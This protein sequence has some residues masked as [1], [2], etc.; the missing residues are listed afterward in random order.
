MKLKEKKSIIKEGILVKIV[1]NFFKGLEQGV[2]DRY[3]A[4]AKKAGAHPEMVNAMKRMD[5]ENEKFRSIMK[6]HGF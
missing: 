6:K 5:D 4:A 1:D 2:A 3:A